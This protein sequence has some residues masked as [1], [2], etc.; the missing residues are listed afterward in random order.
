MGFGD[1]QWD[2][3]MKFGFKLHHPVTPRMWSL[4]HQQDC[5]TCELVCGSQAKPS[6]ATTG[7]GDNPSDHVELFM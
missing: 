2:L 4:G 6:F 7:K 5:D 1:D 3:V